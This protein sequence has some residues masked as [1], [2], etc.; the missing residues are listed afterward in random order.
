MTSDTDRR[1]Q[2]LNGWAVLPSSIKRPDGTPR[3]T[4]HFP[5]SFAKD[6][7]ALHLASFELSIGYEPPTRSLIERT[8]RAGDVFVDVGA[9]WGFFTHQA[10]TH[11]AGAIEVIAFEPDIINATVLTENVARNK[12]ANVTVVCAACGNTNE[13]APLVTNSSMG[14]SIRGVGLV[15]QSLRGPSKWVPVVTLDGALANLQKPGD[16]RVVLKIDVEGFEPN[17]VLGALSLL[18]SGRVALIVW[19]CGQAFAA[20]A[21]HAAMAKMTQ[22]LSELGFR[23]FRPPESTADLPLVPFDVASGHNGNVFSF[24]PQLHE[25]LPS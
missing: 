3:F 16:R 20:G 11:P 14:H 9:H 18:R 24:A 5:A 17:V 10:A 2:T 19:E 15:A 6:Q 1:L 23:H 12:L 21:G 25:A 8:L 7:G 13:L 22:L 4:L